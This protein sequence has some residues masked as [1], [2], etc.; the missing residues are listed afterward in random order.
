MPSCPR[1]PVGNAARWTQVPWRARG[2][3]CK[4]QSIMTHIGH[5]CTSRHSMT[6]FGVDVECPQGT[7]GLERG[8]SLPLLC[9]RV[10]ALHL[11]NGTV[12]T[13]RMDTGIHCF[14]GSERI[15]HA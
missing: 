11:Y 5:C 14:H 3:S 12:Q 1:P 4:L 9:H 10:D 6:R 8:A 7:L 15:P 13:I 2:C